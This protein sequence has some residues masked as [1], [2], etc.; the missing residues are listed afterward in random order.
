MMIRNQVLLL[1]K[2][3]VVCLSFMCTMRTVFAYLLV[4][5]GLLNVGITSIA[6]YPILN[7]LNKVAML[8]CQTT[9]ALLFYLTKLLIMECK[10]SNTTPISLAPNETFD[11]REENLMERLEKMMRENLENDMAAHPV[12]L[13]Y[14]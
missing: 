6:S 9:N 1:L 13:V 7:L 5:G 14:K 11:K 2:Q 10:E 12:E 3:I 4:E 8:Q